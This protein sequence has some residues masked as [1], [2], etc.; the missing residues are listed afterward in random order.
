[1]MREGKKKKRIPSLVLSDLIPFLGL[2]KVEYLIFFEKHYLETSISSI[3]G[4]LA[5]P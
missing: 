3:Y 5:N 4:R 2:C 1:M